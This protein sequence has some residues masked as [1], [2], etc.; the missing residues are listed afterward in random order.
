MRMELHRIPFPR[1]ESVNPIDEDVYGGVFLTK[2][3][4]KRGAREVLAHTDSFLVSHYNAFD[5]Q[6]R[7]AY[8]NQEDNPEA[9]VPLTEL[10]VEVAV[11]LLTDVYLFE[12]ANN[13]D[14]S[15]GLSREQLESQYDRETAKSILAKHSQRNLPRF[16]LDENES[17]LYNE[18]SS[19][20]VRDIAKPLSRKKLLNVS[21]GGTSGQSRGIGDPMDQDIY[22]GVW[23]NRKIWY[24]PK[25][26]LVT[27]K[28]SSELAQHAKRFDGLLRDALKRQ[29]EIILQH[30][31][32]INP[33]NP[34]PLRIKTISQ[35]AQTG[36]EF[37]TDIY[38]FELSKG[39]TSS[40][41]E[42]MI[43]DENSKIAEAILAKKSKGAHEKGSELTQEEEAFYDKILNI[44]ASQYGK[45]PPLQTINLLLNTK[46]SYLSL[47]GRTSEQR[48]AAQPAG[49][50]T[51]SS[52]AAMAAEVPGSIAMTAFL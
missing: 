38:L 48:T 25:F 18:I 32:D 20:A 44:A 47:L 19:L 13:D 35:E 36:I 2:I 17:L 7:T 24:K 27:V 12:L 29:Q 31:K 11:K 10:Q 33:N 5:L 39:D 9:E 21:C 41:L 42:H 26:G 52:S 43:D 3:W 8:Q 22:G 34:N 4:Y 28:N 16:K 23:S 51:G 50:G 37:L 40:D 30:V 46:R 1:T 49:P 14:L 6:S 45:M 15:H